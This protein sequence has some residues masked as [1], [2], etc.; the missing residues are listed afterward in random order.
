M[1]QGITL[2]YITEEDKATLDTAQSFRTLETTMA[3]RKV[4]EWIDG[5]A[6]QAR[7]MAADGSRDSSVSTEV[8]VRLSIRRDVA[9]ELAAMIRGA[10][11]DIKQ[12]AL[13]LAE[14]LKKETE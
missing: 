10:I 8:Y 11:H 13:Q 4:M 7:Q 9:E 3:Y 1:R 5:F 14:E 12:H 2:T 6:A